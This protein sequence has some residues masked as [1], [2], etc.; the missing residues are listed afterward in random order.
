MHKCTHCNQSL[1]L[2]CS[3]QVT[4]V[5]PVVSMVMCAS[6]FLSIFPQERLFIWEAL[7]AMFESKAWKAVLQSFAMC[8]LLFVTMFEFEFFSLY[9]FLCFGLTSFISS[10]TPCEAS[11]ALA[12]VLPVG[13]GGARRCGYYMCQGITP[14][15]WYT[16]MMGSIHMVNRAD[17]TDVLGQGFLCMPS[18][19]SI[20][21]I[22]DVDSMNHE[23]R[24]DMIYH[25]SKLTWTSTIY[26]THMFWYLRCN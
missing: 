1:G 4:G 3:W 2:G 19:I 6:Q 10:L 15:G 22:I 12:P 8:M 25:K 18:D 16:G 17:A 23:D 11:K 13:P 21:I 7:I 9:V 5:R 20:W 24:Y 26:I 14:L